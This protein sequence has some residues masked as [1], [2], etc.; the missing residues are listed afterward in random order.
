VKGQNHRSR[1]L[2][3]YQSQPMLGSATPVMVARMVATC[4]D[5]SGDCVG[6]AATNG[7]ISTGADDFAM[8]LQGVAD[9]G[10]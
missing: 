3:R 9:R 4:F 8:C 1:Q 10:S 5:P 2:L 7:E 6:I